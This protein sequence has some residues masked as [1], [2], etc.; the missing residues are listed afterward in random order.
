[1]A[2]ENLPGEDSGTTRTRIIPN[3]DVDVPDPTLG[4]GLR[5]AM[6]RIPGLTKKGL[7]RSAFLFQVPPLETI[8]EQYAGTHQEFGTVGSGT[9]SRYQ[10]KQLRQVGFSS[11]FVDYKPA[12]SLLDPGD[13][14]AW[15]PNPLLMRDQLINICEAGTP[16]MLLVHLAGY[17][18]KYDV[19]WPATLRSVKVDQR[20]GEIGTRYFDVS[21]S[22]YRDPRVQRR[23]KGAKRTGPPKGTSAHHLPATVTLTGDGRGH[24]NGHVFKAVTMSSLAR[25][26]YGSP[27]RWRAIAQ[28][29]NLDAAGTRPLWD[30]THTLPPRLRHSKKIIV[31]KLG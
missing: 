13:E 4:E 10:G 26:F 22:E 18:Q 28:R 19:V 15:T 9:F 3:L 17:N 31:P 27:S 8:S 7:L 29:N 1:M 14:K 11:M 30:S 21:F 20:A 24:W 12:W 23:A 2:F 25:H 5:V 6:R 16:F